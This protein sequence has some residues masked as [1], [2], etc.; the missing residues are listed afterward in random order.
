[1][2]QVR[3]RAVV[4]PSEDPGKVEKAVRNLFPNASLERGDGVVTAAADSLQDLRNLIWK[5]KILDASRRSLLRS[6]AED[7]RHAAF[8]L[9]KMAAFKGRVSFS[10]E[11]GSP[12]GDI[13]VAVEGPGLEDLFKEIAPM[14]LRGHPVSEEE[15]ERE[16]ARRRARTRPTVLSPEQEVVREVEAEAVADDALDEDDEEAAG[17]EDA[18]AE[19]EDDEG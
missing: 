4:H 11:L 15:A 18:D 9:N 7:N 13:E 5:Q 19:E 14:T 17:A 16:L 12:L 8:R 2:L 10:E 6:V 3:V 1:M